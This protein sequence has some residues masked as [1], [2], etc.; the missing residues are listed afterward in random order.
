MEIQVIFQWDRFRRIENIEILTISFP[1]LPT[2]AG[3]MCYKFPT[4]SRKAFKTVEI[5]Q[6]TIIKVRSMAKKSKPKFKEIYLT[7]QI[8][9]HKPRDCNFWQLLKSNFLTFSTKNTNEQ[10]DDYSIMLNQLLLQHS[11]Q[12][13]HEFL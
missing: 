10:Y 4:F 7:I 2:Y 5:I 1:S 6:K 8:S 12:I 11:Y 9:Q 13:E 3:K